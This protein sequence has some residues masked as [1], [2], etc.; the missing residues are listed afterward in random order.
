M[1]VLLE[2]LNVGCDGAA[3]EKLTVLRDRLVGLR[4]QTRGELKIN[5][6]VMELVCAKY[7]IQLGYDVDLEHKLS[8][9][10][11]CDVYGTFKGNDE[12]PIVGD[13]LIIE[14]ETGFVSPEHALDPGTSCR[15]KVASKITRYSKFSK[16]FALGTPP[17]NILEIPKVFVK[18]PESRLEE[19]LEDVRKL[20]RPYYTNPLISIEDV[21]NAKIHTV[22]VIDVDKIQV[23]S[24]GVAK[25]IELCNVL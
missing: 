23:R 14:I 10:Q 4:E 9:N 16:K 20:C 12:T 17:D 6:S 22:Y 5:H 11:K 2:K 25:Y 15:A 3:I 8:E 13:T 21:R 19:E 7:L 24:Y 18:P 1:D